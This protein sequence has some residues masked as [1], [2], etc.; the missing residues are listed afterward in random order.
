MPV[1][2][3]RTV[4]RLLREALAIVIAAAAVGLGINLCNPRGYE[5]V[6]R[7]V[8]AYRS[9][10]SITADEAKAKYDAGIARFFD[11]RDAEEF[12][13]ARVAGAI[14]VPAMDGGPPPPPGEKKEAVIYCDGPGCGASDILARRM[15]D[16][17]HRGLVYVLQGGLPEWADRG[18]PMERGEKNGR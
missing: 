18:Y 4:R 8:P 14:S 10:V 6:P 16:G 9:V 5:P 2:G 3:T 15:I 1:E 17:G 13:E 11:A 12:A 7:R